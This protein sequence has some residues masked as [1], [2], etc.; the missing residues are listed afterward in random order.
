LERPSGQKEVE[1]LSTGHSD[2]A[3]ATYGRGLAKNFRV[4]DAPAV[5]RRSARNDLVHVFVE[6]LLELPVSYQNATIRNDLI[7]T[8]CRKEANNGEWR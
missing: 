5:V 2:A 8:L 1:A 3:F 6:D 7:A 4:D